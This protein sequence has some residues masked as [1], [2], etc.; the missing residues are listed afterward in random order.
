MCSL[1]ECSEVVRGKMLS[2]HTEA[3][4]EVPLCENVLKEEALRLNRWG[5][6]RCKNRMYI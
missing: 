5:N 4:I 2:G 3:A 6:E 1:V